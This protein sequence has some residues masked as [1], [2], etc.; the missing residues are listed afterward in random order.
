M[1]DCYI[2]HIFRTPPHVF[3][4]ENIDVGN[5]GDAGDVAAARLS[6]EDPSSPSSVASQSTF[7]NLPSPP[8]SERGAQAPHIVTQNIAGTSQQ[9]IFGVNTLESRPTSSW[10]DLSVSSLSGL[11]NRRHRLKL[12]M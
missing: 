10:R 3:V 4:F 9:H 7:I 5:G 8:N 12:K 6:Q 1:Y 11:L 2:L